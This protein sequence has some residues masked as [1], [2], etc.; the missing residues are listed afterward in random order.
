MEKQ[1]KVTN[2]HKWEIKENGDKV[3]LK[4]GSRINKNLG[5]LYYERDKFGVLE[6]V[7]WYPRCYPLKDIFVV[8]KDE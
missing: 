8:K 7:N 3:C 2:R 5:Y 4:C 1:N 6:P